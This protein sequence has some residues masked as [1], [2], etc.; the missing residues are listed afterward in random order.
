[1]LKRHYFE[2]KYNAIPLIIQAFQNDLTLVEDWNF[3]RV[4]NTVSEKSM[5]T[6]EL[7]Q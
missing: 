7:S 6:L 4:E 5:Y 3:V 1:M 2:P